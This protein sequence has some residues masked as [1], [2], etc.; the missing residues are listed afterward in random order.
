MNKK[1]T[2][3]VFDFGGVLLDIDYQR[4]YD[5]LSKLLNI[6]FDPDHLPDDAKKVLFDFETGH[7]NTESFIWNIQRMSSNQTPPQAQEI[8]DAWNAMLIGWNPEK[9]AFLKEL[10]KKY[11]LY[12]LS[13]TNEIHLNWVYKDL[14]ENHGISDF[15]DRFFNKTYYSHLIGMRKPNKDI[16]SFVQQNAKLDP[17]KTL[18]IDDIQANIKGGESAGWHTYHHDP[19]EDLINIF[20]NQLKLL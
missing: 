12:L 13:N 20:R 17:S 8:K 15:D 16:F 14:K 1:I 18:F 11:A 6:S 19:N 4:T 9:F 2:S 10:K 5:A 3:I 7:I